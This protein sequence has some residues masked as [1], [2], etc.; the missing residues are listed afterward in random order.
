MLPTTI[1]LIPLGVAA[2]KE[3]LS[4]VPSS[5]LQ[6]TFGSSLGHRK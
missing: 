4:P 2:S 5:D 1:Q 3:C 6:C